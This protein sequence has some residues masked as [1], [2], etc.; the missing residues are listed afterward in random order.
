[1]EQNDFR[2][3]VILSRHLSEGTGVDHEKASRI[4]GVPCRLE[5]DAL[6]M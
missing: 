2:L 4:S 5:L 1:L 3:I 6:R